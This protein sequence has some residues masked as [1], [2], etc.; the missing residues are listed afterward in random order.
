MI[1]K[2]EADCLGHCLESVR[3]LVDEIVVLDTGSSDATVAVARSFGA[4]IG[5]FPWCDDFS[6]AR[7][8]SLQLC[9]GDWVLV[10]DADE[11]I[12]PLDHGKIRRALEPRPDPGAKGPQ[13]FRLISRNYMMDS[14]ARLFDQQAQ[15]NRSAYREGAQFPYY[16]DGWIFRLFRR[17][18]DLRF[19]GRIHERADPFLERR[20]L[21]IGRLDAVIHHYGKLDPGEEE[22]KRPYY[23]E[24]AERDAAEVPGDVNRQFFVMVQADLLGQWDKALQA[25]LAAMKLQPRGLPYVV[26]VT[27]ARAYQQLGK[28]AK[29]APLLLQVLKQH[30]DHPQ[31]AC[32]LV[33]S[34]LDL[35]RVEDARPHLERLLAAHPQEPMIH[36]SFSHLEE[37]TGR[38]AEARQHLC[39]AIAANPG[40]KSLR[41]LLVQQDLRLGLTA[42]AAADA[43][44]ALRA[45]PGE[46]G[47][48]WHALAAG[49][50]LKDG[51]LGPGK[52]VLDLGLARFPDNEDLRKLAAAL[53]APGGPAE[54]AG[55]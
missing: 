44:D 16:A 34:L 42:R 11:A 36:V 23:L 15:P 25:G 26:P 50:L 17:L 30:P 33:Y 52:A 54:A 7:N 40:D 3:G 31:A 45:L 20:R 1:T 5:Q 46:G 18:P 14:L 10:L 39:A 41:H 6:A 38:L 43:M 2:N 51:H 22:A 32:A 55:T 19:E 48:Q 8:A 13:G 37:A 4:R 27:V 21:P 24:L 9:T 49:F 12:D 47:G 35:G 29:A 53:P 28:H